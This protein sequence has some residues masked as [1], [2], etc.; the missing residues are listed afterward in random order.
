MRVLLVVCLLGIGVPL[1][2][3]TVRPL[4]FT[5]LVQESTAVV[6]GRVIEVRGQWTADRG[7]IE[8]LVLVEAAAYLKGALGDRVTVRVAGGEV[9]KFVNIIPGAPRFTP[10]DRVVLF[11]KTSGPSIPVI[12]GTSQGV[13]R[14]STDTASGASVV[15]PPVVDTTTRATPRGDLA[16]RPLPLPAFEDAV[17]RAEAAR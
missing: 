11:L 8:S 12:T 2:A 10:G 13:Y 1:S 5:E 14:V 17:R 9:G 15:V 4:T 3:L 7:G 16:R 6:Q